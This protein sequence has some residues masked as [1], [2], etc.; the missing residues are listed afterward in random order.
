MGQYTGY[1][2]IIQEANYIGREVE[3]I[4]TWMPNHGVL[5]TEWEFTTGNNEYTKIQELRLC[6]W[7]TDLLKPGDEEDTW[8]MMGVSRK[9]PRK[10]SRQFQFKIVQED[11][12]IGETNNTLYLS[13]V[14]RGYDEKS[15]DYQ[16]VIDYFSI[17]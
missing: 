16:T 14:V 7:I 12:A 15:E 17:K 11:G 6:P 8:V 2:N 5:Q 13:G 3:P 10:S 4:P 1:A 9:Q